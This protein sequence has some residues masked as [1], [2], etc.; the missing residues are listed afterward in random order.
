MVK[1]AVEGHGLLAVTTRKALGPMLHGHS[2]TADLVWFCEDTPVDENDVGDV[3][4]IMNQIRAHLIAK[5]P[6]ST[7]IMISSQVPVGFC[8]RLEEL[9]P[10][11]TWIVQPENIRREHADHD[12]HW[13]GRM[14]V[15]RRSK[16]HDELI[17][18]VLS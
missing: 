18:Q 5:V 11:W 6:D 15:G 3:Q 13:Q 12:F 9:W 1:V 10:E 17:R 4:W 8:A 7:P 2:E 14:V 16:E